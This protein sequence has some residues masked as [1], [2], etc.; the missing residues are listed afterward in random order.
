MPAVKS[1]IDVPFLYPNFEMM[2]P[3]GI[4]AKKYPK[5]NAS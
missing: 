3:D 4:A 5:K 1:P 2:L